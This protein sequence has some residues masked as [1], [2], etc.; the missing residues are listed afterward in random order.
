M[1]SKPGIL[2]SVVRWFIASI[3]TLVLLGVA[4][5]VCLFS[6]T[7]AFNISR[8]WARS[9]LKIFCITLKKV[10]ENQ[11]Y[12]PYGNLYI[13]LNQTTLLETVF[14]PYAMPTEF[15]VIVNLEFALVPII[16]WLNWL[17][18]GVLLIRQW[19]AQA[20]RAMGKAAEKLKL[21]SNL[22]I[23]IEGQRSVD[24]SL[25]PYKKGAAV[26]ALSSQAVVTPIF[27][28]G[29]RDRL[30]YGEW[31]V[32]PGEV[33]MRFLKSFQLKG[34]TYEDRDLIVTRLRKIAETQS[35]LNSPS[36]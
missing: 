6:K 23:S 31:R 4:S 1:E 29:A 8:I 27:Y 36:K 25:R 17:L 14:G 12:D 5:L 13:T 10:D 26:L 9:I 7:L 21:K 30:P 3:V 18:G 20:R 35:R 16:G 34:L 33:E 32:R 2:I 22:W 11:T 19:P 28:V 24:G 15:A